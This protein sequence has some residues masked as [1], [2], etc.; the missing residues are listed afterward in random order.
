MNVTSTLGLAGHVFLVHGHR[1]RAEETWGELREV[2]ERSQ[3]AN[4]QIVL[5]SLSARLAL[6]D[7]RLEDALNM[8]LQVTDRGEELGL[9]GFAGSYVHGSEAR[10][11]LHLGQADQY[12]Q[13]G[14]AETDTLLSAG[15]LF[16]AH[17][18]GDGEAAD[19]LEQVVIARPGIG[20]SGDEAPVDWWDAS[21]LQAAVLTK[22]H[23]AAE[24]LLNRLAG[25]SIR[26]SGLFY[27]TC[28][29]R[30]LGAAAALLGRP[31]ESRSHYLEALEVATDMRFRPE[32]ALT[33]LQLA[34]L[35]LERCPEDKSEALEHL[36]FTINEFREMKM[37]PSL[38][39][40]LKHKEVLGA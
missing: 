16:L 13:Q 21:L 24:L 36:D 23:V 4:L 32:I 39:R 11:R 9:S 2:A 3:Q 31:E 15:A 28:I 38:E 27:P 19:I 7:G 14:L 25:S 26:T 29:G 1:E 35:L 17:L 30:H 10:A 33:R 37:Q 6:M 34:E 8:S 18:G 20:T 22:H 40:A 12:L 5:L